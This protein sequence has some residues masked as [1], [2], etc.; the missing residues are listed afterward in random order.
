M[1]GKAQRKRLLKVLF[2]LLFSS[3]SSSSSFFTGC[4][5]QQ[6]S[7]EADSEAPSFVADLKL[8]HGVVVFIQ[9]LLF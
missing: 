6:F 2:H 5:E 7:T 1:G 8:R 4:A 9:N 3:P